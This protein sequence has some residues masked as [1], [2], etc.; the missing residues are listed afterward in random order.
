MR[1]EPITVKAAERYRKEIA[2]LYYANIRSCSFLDHFS[3]KDAYKK[4]GGFIEHLKNQT[5]ISYG[6]FENEEL[7]GF[8]WAFPHQ[9]REEKRLYVNEIRV[10]EEYRKKGFGSQLINMVEDKAKELG[11]SAVYL[12]AEAD[13]PEAVK[14]YETNG[15]GRERI[16][17]R[18]N[19]D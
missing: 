8:I 12:H 18:K 2:R 7:C 5:A 11:I 13:N 3:S 19:L 4:I 9:F 15:Y 6:V 1:I 14:F 17:L 16:Q 10:K